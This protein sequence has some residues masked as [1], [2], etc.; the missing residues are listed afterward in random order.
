LATEATKANFDQ[1]D[2]HQLQPP[3]TPLM[4]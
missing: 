1:Q 2:S 4:Q 3:R